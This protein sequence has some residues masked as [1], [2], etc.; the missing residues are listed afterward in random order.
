M[1]FQQRSCERCCDRGEKGTTVWLDTIQTEC[2]KG[3]S[4]KAAI[5]RTA[6]GDGRSAW[7]FKAVDSA[8]GVTTESSRRVRE[9]DFCSFDTTGPV[10]MTAV[11][12]ERP[13]SGAKLA[14][15]SRPNRT[16]VLLLP[17]LALAGQDCILQ[18]G[19]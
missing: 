8:I 6:C 19:L 13:I 4:D 18:A 10:A 7:T 16:E 1:V 9:F 12:A 2:R 11:R 5:G 17:I 15:M 3:V 14:R